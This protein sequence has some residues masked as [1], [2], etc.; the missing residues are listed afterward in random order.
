MHADRLRL[1]GNYSSDD[2]YLARGFSSVTG[3]SPLFP[4]EDRYGFGTSGT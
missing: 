2:S 1:M 4:L 3:D